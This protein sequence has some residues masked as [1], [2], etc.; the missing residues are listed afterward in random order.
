MEYMAKLTIDDL[1]LKGK[2]VLVRVDFN[3][4]LNDKLEVTD[5]T[6]IRAAL[7]TIEK[8]IEAGGKAIL[9]S[10]LG[11]PKGKVIESLRL[12]PAARRLSQLLNKEVTILN[13][14]IGK[15][16][17]TAI[18]QMKQGE[19]AVLENV[20]FYEGETANDPEFA[21]Q[22]AQLGDLYVNDA[23]GTAHRAHASTA[24]VTRYFDQCAMGY[25]IQ[26]E[27]KYLSLVVENPTR[28]FVAIMGGA[29]ISGKI[30][31]IENLLAKVDSLLIGGGMAYTFF[32]AQGIN[33]GN[34]LLE[35]DKLDLARKVLNHVKATNINLVLPQ[36]NII[37][38]EISGITEIK[39]TTGAAV[40]D[41]W[42]GVDIGQRTI[43][44]FEELINS[45]NTIVWNGPMGIFENERFAHG[46]I[47]IA[48]ALAKQTES[49]AIT[50]VG[51]GD[52]VA[53]LALANVT[54]K[55]THVSTGGGAS[56]EFLSGVK[57]PGIEALTDK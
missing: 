44:R 46:T 39:E 11:R 40:P 12:A 3:V 30:D 36:D 45:A 5:D 56:L 1:Y 15:T 53:A 37:A 41:D 8:I 27:L 17:E 7:P 19:V 24:G 21:K 54:D 16:V 26:K 29:K 22:L 52:S 47:A 57:L 42:I 20:R 32:K 14:C 6:R 50:V 49:G 51:G 10:H 25:L 31:V 28:P 2:R 23:F 4:P 55:I 18:K 9:M 35:A 34:S 48:K 43:N 33:I 38:K 13:D